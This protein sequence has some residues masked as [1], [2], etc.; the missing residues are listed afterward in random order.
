MW[1]NL[2]S[3]VYAGLVRVGSYSAVKIRNTW[4]FTLSSSNGFVSQSLPLSN[5]WDYRISVPSNASKAYYQMYINLTPSSPIKDINSVGISGYGQTSYGTGFSAGTG[6]SGRLSTWIVSGYI[7]LSNPS[8]N[9]GTLS[10]VVDASFN[11]SSFSSGSVLA[12]PIS[13]AFVYF[14]DD[15]SVVTDTD[16]SQQTDDL[17]NGFDNSA[18]SQ[19]ADQLGQ[20]VD[21]YLKQEDSLYDQ[22]QYDVPEIDLLSDARGIVLASGFMQSLYVS[23]EFISKIVTFSLSFG[24]ILFI[25]GWLK[26]RGS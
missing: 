23:N 2:S 6:S 10:F 5:L 4:T 9:L 12:E 19:A 20:Q 21:D 1:W 11:S 18:G 14:A 16:L 26:K 25:V 8:I 7:D 13:L 15:G 3:N 24:L 17:T 22:M